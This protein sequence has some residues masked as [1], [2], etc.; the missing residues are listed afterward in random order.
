MKQAFLDTA[1]EEY[2]RFAFASEAMLARRMY[3]ILRK[4]I[5]GDWSFRE[6]EAI[7]GEWDELHPE[8]GVVF[9]DDESDFDD[10]ESCV[11]SENEDVEDD[12]EVDSEA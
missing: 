7:I 6:A 2:K 11:S 8:D 4:G 5:F 1:S 9:V 3:Y 12:V 10:D